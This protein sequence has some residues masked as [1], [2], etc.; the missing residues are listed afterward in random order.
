MAKV[1]EKI[2][3]K[4]SCTTISNLTTYY[5]KANMDLENIIQQNSPPLN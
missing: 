5:I 4:Y 2:I 1:L 3:N